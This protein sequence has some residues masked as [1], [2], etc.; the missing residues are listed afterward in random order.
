MPVRRPS[1]RWCIFRKSLS[2]P[3]DSSEDFTISTHARLMNYLSAIGASDAL[4]GRVI[5]RRQYRLVSSHSVAAHEVRRLSGCWLPVK[6]LTARGVRR[7][8]V[9][10]SQ[11][12]IEPAHVRIG[13]NSIRSGRPTRRNMTTAG[14][15]EAIRCVINLITSVACISH[16]NRQSVDPTGGSLSVSLCSVGLDTGRRQGEF[17]QSSV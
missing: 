8:S 15:E 6:S 4:S 17:Q 5:G 1:F 2:L 16:R 10:L 12:S 14:S 3:D 13:Y 7:S 11:C 9:P